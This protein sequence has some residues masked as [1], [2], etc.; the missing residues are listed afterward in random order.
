M[1]D[2]ACH[3]GYEQARAEATK[4]RNCPS[5]RIR[6][7][8]R[9]GDGSRALEPGEQG[10]SALGEKMQNGP[11][12]GGRKGSGERI[13]IAERR[14]RGLGPLRLRMHLRARQGMEMG[15]S[16][17]RCVYWVLGPG[18]WDERGP[19][20]TR[21]VGWANERTS[22]RRRTNNGEPRGSRSHS[23]H[24]PQSKRRSKPTVVRRRN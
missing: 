20:Q 23:T 4:M 8:W 16:W 18:R 5:M 10:Q 9:D 13:W 21:G 24:P 17:R 15:C 22:G 19:Y 7:T 2:G 6:G 12:A 3:V 1:S 14:R 11:A